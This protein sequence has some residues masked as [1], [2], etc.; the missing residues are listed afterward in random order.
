[1]HE[2]CS[3][4]QQQNTSVALS[5]RKFAVFSVFLGQIP[6]EPFKT[7]HKDFLLKSP[8]LRNE[9]HFSPDFK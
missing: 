6:R 4:F 8:V 1:M 3:L 9:V 7:V 5:R 2:K